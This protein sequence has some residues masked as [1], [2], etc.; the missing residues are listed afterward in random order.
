MAQQ[1]PGRGFGGS[2][3][4]TTGN[5]GYRERAGHGNRTE[6][7]PQIDTSTIVFG[8]Q[9][10]PRLFSDIAEDCAKAVA[11][12][13]RGN[14]VNKGTQLRRFYDEL[15][16][17]QNKVGSSDERFRTHAPFIQMLKAKVAYAV[18]RRKVD[19]NFERLLRRVIDQATDHARLAQAKLFMEAFMA[20]YKVH[21]PRD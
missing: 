12:Q 9:I 10:D 14:D 7:T 8:E 5:P 4:P 1:T 16:M 13:G 19:A 20:F 11:P 17:L 15:V 2:S 3:R 18:G 21:G 6:D